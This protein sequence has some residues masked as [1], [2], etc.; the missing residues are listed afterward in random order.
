MKTHT[1]THATAKKSKKRKRHKRSRP[2]LAIVAANTF[3]WCLGLSL[4][5]V[6]MQNNFNLAV[7]IG[8]GIASFIYWVKNG[9]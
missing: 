3:L 6:I 9:G 4:W 5:S 1:G 8:L 7:F 2:L